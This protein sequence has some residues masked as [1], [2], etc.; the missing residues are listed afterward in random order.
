MLLD[1]LVTGYCFYKVKPSTA[2]QN[3]V[4]EV[5]NPLNTFIDKNPDS[6]YIKDSYRTVVRY[7]MTK[8]QILH[9]YG[10]QL[11]KEDLKIIEDEWKDVDDHSFSYITSTRLPNINFIEGNKIVG[12]PKSETYRYNLIPV[13][14]VEWLETDEDFVVNRYST[15]RIG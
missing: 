8:S 6:I 10:R 13:Y 4:I 9:K 3:I 11:K 2:G 15:I 5:L 12:K 7:W 14:E 1:L